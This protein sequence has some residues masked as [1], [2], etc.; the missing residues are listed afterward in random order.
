MARYNAVAKGGFYPMPLHLAA[1]V[2]AMLRPDWRQ[3]AECRLVDPC[4]G[5]GAALA[6]LKTW[7]GREPVYRGDRRVDTYACEMEPARWEILRQ[8]D[9]KRQAPCD[10]PQ[11]LLGDFFQVKCDVGMADVLFLNP[12][13]DVGRDGRR[14]EAR[15]LEVASSMAIQGGVLVFVVPYYV[16]GACAAALALH[17]T[18]LQLFRFPGADFDA[19]RQVVV[20]GRRVVRTMADPDV[21]AW[22]VA[23][24]ESVEGAPELPAM[25]EHLLDAAGSYM[26]EEFIEAHGRYRA[27]TRWNSTGGYRTLARWSLV[28]FDVAGVAEIDP[29]ANDRGPIA[30][31]ALP[32]DLSASVNA[33]F[34]I[35]RAHV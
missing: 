30:G 5:E 35:G 23:M 34:Q 9:P 27:P 29:W 33:V 31:L 4:A 28:G 18:D 17:Y 32:A 15:F 8:T 2:G 13:Y 26:A 22:A 14:L 11:H 19:F 21:A 16:L 20:F 1:T 12:P 6:C 7:I 10:P 25:P 24:G 3:G